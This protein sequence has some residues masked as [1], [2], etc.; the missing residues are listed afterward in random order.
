MTRPSLKGRLRVPLALVQS[1]GGGESGHSASEAV[2]AGLFKPSATSLSPE[3][4]LARKDAMSARRLS[5]PGLGRG[6]GRT[7]PTCMARRSVAAFMD[8]ERAVSLGVERRWVA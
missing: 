7:E 3:L 6:A 8:T 4:S 1:M 5:A 2:V